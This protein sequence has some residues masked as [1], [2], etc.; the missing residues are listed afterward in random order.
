[1]ILIMSTVNINDSVVQIADII[2]GSTMQHL[3]DNRLQMS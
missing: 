3:L 2:A 1:M